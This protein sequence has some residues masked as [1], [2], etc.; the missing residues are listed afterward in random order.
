MKQIITLCI[1]ACSLTLTNST[2]G[3]L[4]QCYRAIQLQQN[5]I[6]K[7]NCWIASSAQKYPSDETFIL[8]GEVIKLERQIKVLKQENEMLLATIDNYNQTGPE[9]Q[10]K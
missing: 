5:Y 6:Q 10:K 8:R 9:Q 4:K 3:M 2:G 1:L 7:R